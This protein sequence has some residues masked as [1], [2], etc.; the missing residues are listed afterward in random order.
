MCIDRFTFSVF[1]SASI[2]EMCTAEAIVAS[3]NVALRFN[4]SSVGCA[5]R[6]S[7]MALH[8]SGLSKRPV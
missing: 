6:E 4:T 3:V 1:T 5:S 8:V 2:R 7:H